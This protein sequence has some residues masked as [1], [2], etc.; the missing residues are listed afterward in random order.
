MTTLTTPTTLNPIT[1]PAGTM[2]WLEKALAP[3]RR[4]ATQRTMRE[5][6]EMLLARAEAY[7]ATQPSYAADL[8]AGAAHILDAR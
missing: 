1:A 3:W 2:G 6:A 7:E 5:G 8:R 4:S